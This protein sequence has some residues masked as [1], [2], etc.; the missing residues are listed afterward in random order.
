MYRFDE[1]AVEWGDR[2]EGVPIMNRLRTIMEIIVSYYL[3]RDCKIS[4]VFI[5]EE[6]RLKLTIIKTTDKETPFVFRGD[7]FGAALKE[8]I[9]T[10][11]EE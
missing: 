4:G 6:N 3:P 5:D 7:T 11:Y 1:T 8:A 2:V 10:T 9:D